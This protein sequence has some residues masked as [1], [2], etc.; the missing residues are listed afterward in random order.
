[1]MG[2]AHLQLKQNDGAADYMQEAFD[3]GYRNPDLILALAQDLGSNLDYKPLV[4]KR[5]H[6]PHRAD[7]F[8]RG[9]QPGVALRGDGHARE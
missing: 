3:L 2:D 5:H 6:T 7:D 1:M 8:R 4:L 9:R